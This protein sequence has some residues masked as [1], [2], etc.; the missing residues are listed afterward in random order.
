MTVNSHPLFELMVSRFKS[1]RMRRI[2][3]SHCEFLYPSA[4]NLFQNDQIDEF[5]T[6]LQGNNFEPSPLI[7]PND[8]TSY[9]LAKVD[10]IVDIDGS[11]T[12]GEGK[13]EFLCVKSQRISLTPNQQSFTNSSVIQYMGNRKTSPIIR[14][15][16]C[17]K[18]QR[19]N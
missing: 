15:L 18:L 4:T 17:L 16:F 10:N 5:A 11:I 12:R 9:Y 7:L 3:R 2:K 13:I 8:L 19:L 14:F 6:W 1:C